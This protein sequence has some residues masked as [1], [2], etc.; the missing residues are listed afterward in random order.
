MQI[1]QKETKMCLLSEKIRYGNVQNPQK[2][3]T[4][5]ITEF[6]KVVGYMIKK[7]IFLLINNDHSQY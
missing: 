3:I 4:E 1:R 2:Q 7:I 6:K 5:L